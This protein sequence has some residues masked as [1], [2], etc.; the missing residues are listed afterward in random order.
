LTATAHDEVQ[1]L[2]VGIIR[3][4][5]RSDEAVWQLDFAG[6]DWADDLEDVFE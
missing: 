2:A 3:L 5:L 1:K 6:V 4:T